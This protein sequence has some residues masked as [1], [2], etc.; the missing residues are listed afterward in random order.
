ML[1]LGIE[2]KKETIFFLNWIWDSI[3]DWTRDLLSGYTSTDSHTLPYAVLRF[4]LL[5]IM[6]QTSNFCQVGLLYGTRG[7]RASS[8]QKEIWKTWG[9]LVCIWRQ[10]RLILTTSLTC[11]SLKSMNSVFSYQ[12]VLKVRGKARAAAS[13]IPRPWLAVLKSL[14]RLVMLSQISL[15]VTWMLGKRFLGQLYSKHKRW[16]NIRHIN[17]RLTPTRKSSQSERLFRPPRT[18]P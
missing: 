3:H 11:S 9:S 15:T 10:T 12:M 1:A 2:E 8:F 7:Y 6:G 5:C 18:L 4:T 13:S 14:L 17:V 16:I